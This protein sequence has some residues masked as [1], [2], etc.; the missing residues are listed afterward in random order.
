VPHV[1][2]RWQGPSEDN[3]FHGYLGLSDEIVVTADSVSMLAE[4]CAT[5]RPVH[6]FDIEEGPFAMRAEQGG[7]A[8]NPPPI[9]W[10]GRNLETTLFRF[11]INHLP[12]RFSRD[13][14]I[15]HRALDA[16][17][18]ASWLEGDAVPEARPQ[19]AAE[20]NRELARSAARIRELF[21]L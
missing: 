14:R 13:L 16:S 21:G 8:D 2:Y 1:L 9:G 5:G 7:T 3:P 15:F 19:R 12:A 17:G 10:R 6:L 20:P 18:K 11:L 4:A